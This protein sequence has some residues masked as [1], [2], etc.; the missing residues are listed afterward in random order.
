[1]LLIEANTEGYSKEK[2]APNHCR[3]GCLSVS[4]QG[5]FEAALEVVESDA[6]NA[7]E[8]QRSSAVLYKVNLTV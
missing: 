5:K 3:E 7:L 2:G 4:Q 1:M 6:G 8:A